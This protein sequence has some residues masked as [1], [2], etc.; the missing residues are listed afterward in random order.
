MK[1]NNI[2]T[3]LLVTRISVR[4]GLIKIWG[5]E[6]RWPILW[7]DIH[8]SISIWLEEQKSVDMMIKD[9]LECVEILRQ[10]GTITW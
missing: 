2:P 4:R 1:S 6:E 8:P 10:E 3:Q 5:C 9:I 7:E